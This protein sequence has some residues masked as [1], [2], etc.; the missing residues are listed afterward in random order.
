[1]AIKTVS[2]ALSDIGRVRK[3]N[4]DSGYSGYQ[5]FFVA[6]GMGGHAGGDIAS[7]LVS[8]R[9]AQIDGVFAS[10]EA[11]KKSLVHSMQEANRA[12]GQTVKDHSELAGL[13]TTFSG[14]LFTD[15]QVN[16]AHIGDSRV[17]LQ[18]DGQLKQVTIDHTFVQRLVDLGRITPEEALT[19]PRRSV[20]M[21][22]LGD[23]EEQPEID[24]FTLETKPGDRWLLCSD[25]LCG[26]VPENIMG[27]ILNSHAQ[28]EEA[29]DLLV[30][31]ALEYGAPD[32]VTVVVVD[33]LAPNV[34]S[35]FLPS[36]QYVGSAA[37][38]IVI[39]DHRGN[40]L[41]RIFNP[42]LLPDL[43][44]LSQDPAAYQ[45]ESDEYLDYILSQT[46]A[47]IR[48]HRLRQLLIVVLLSLLGVGVLTLGYQY[49]QTRFYVGEFN[50]KIAVYQ[51]IHESL[52]PIKF[53][54]LYRET[55]IDVSALT[56]FQQAAIAQTIIAT[57]YKDA[58][59]EIAALTRV[60]G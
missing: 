58:L 27:G 46:R 55:S 15:N 16:I 56:P 19:H 41:L 6:D 30:S 49:T 25:G 50:G 11:A 5:L 44:G 59:R 36:A 9:V 33:V 17:Y 39:D 4:Q 3:S 1:M 23:I 28:A 60:G 43:L 12:L 52:G 31:E 57:D 21:R 53:S 37:N 45:P 7:A 29:C 38:E 10:P 8:Q 35:D 2:H 42:R 13:G 40:R 48:N 47:K 32:N 51:G 34:E 54:H 14:I 22:V 24:A 18:R 20:L 26:F